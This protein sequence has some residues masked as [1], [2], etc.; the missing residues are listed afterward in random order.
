M[1]TNYEASKVL[2]PKEEGIFLR[3]DFTGLYLQIECEF[4]RNI[5]V[6]IGKIIIPISIRKTQT[7]TKYEFI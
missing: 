5:I 6:K 2:I 7:K 3:T 4:E 1:K